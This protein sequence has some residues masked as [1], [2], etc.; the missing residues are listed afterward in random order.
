MKMV[1]EKKIFEDDSRGYCNYCGFQLSILIRIGEYRETI[2]KITP[3]RRGDLSK[4]PELKSMTIPRKAIYPLLDVSG[5]DEVYVGR[6]REDF[7]PCGL[8]M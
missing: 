4:A 7:I 5:A 2:D 8:N 3:E 1:R 6:I